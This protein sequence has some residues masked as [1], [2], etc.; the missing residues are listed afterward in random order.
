MCMY[1][2]DC[3]GVEKPCMDREPVPIHKPCP[4]CGSNNISIERNDYGLFYAACECSARGGWAC[5][6]KTAWSNWDE[7]V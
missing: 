5:D 6:E 4:H 2:K 1:C 7:R 3:D